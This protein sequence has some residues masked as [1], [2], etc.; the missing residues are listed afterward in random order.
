MGGGSRSRHPSTSQAPVEQ[1]IARAFVQFLQEESELKAPA[2]TLPVLEMARNKSEQLA[3]EAQSSGHAR[4]TSNS[5]PL[6]VGP[7]SPSLSLPSFSSLPPGHSP[8]SLKTVLDT[9]EP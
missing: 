3:A 8:T 5:S 7:H 9:P 6:L 4:S 2:P 1:S